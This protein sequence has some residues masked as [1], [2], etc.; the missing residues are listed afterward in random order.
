MFPYQRVAP[1]RRNGWGQVGK[2]GEEIGERD[3]EVADPQIAMAQA[4]LEA[5]AQ[6]DF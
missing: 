3:Q 2:G 6:V 4:E 1:C 5:A